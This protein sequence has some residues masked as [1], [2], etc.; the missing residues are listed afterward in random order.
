[1]DSLSVAN[2]LPRRN[3]PIGTDHTSNFT[4]WMQGPNNLFDKFHRK[5]CD[6]FLGTKMVKV[7][8]QMTLSEIREFNFTNKYMMDSMKY[9]IRRIQI[10][11]KKD[12]ISP[13]IM[14]C[15]TVN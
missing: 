2:P 12:R 10:T 11:F 4:L 8:R 15:M 13:A 14:E 7:Q 1:M 5:T 3:I 6:F 9:L